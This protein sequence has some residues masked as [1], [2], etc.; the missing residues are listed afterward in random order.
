MRVN[1]NADRPD[2]VYSGARKPR[3][4]RPL[5]QQYEPDNEELRFG[6]QRQYTKVESE[7][8][9]FNT[10]NI[11]STLT[12]D[13]LS[14]VLKAAA[15]VVSGSATT[16]DLPEGSNLYFT[17]ERV[18]DR[19]SVLIQDGTGISWTYDDTANTFIGNV[20]LAPF[21]S[22]DIA[23][24]STNLYYTNARARAA[25]SAGNDIEYDNT[26]GVISH[27]ILRT[28]LLMGA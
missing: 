11:T 28:F 10:V 25:L 16:S 22:D 12:L 26:T 17:D 3:I 5:A 14:G 8:P 7:N 19:V 1:S 20:S 13:N 27:S 15:G 6:S 18:D 9:T 24:G 21:S 4:V 23:E 2:Q